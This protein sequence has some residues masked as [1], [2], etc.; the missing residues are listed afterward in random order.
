MATLGPCD[1][2]E[3]RHQRRGSRRPSSRGS[4]E[5]FNHWLDDRLRQLYERELADPIP[6]DMLELLQKIESAE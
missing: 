1:R 2:R 4:G 5:P 3:R 6:D